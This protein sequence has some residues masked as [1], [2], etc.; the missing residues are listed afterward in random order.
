MATQWGVFNAEGCVEDGLW[1]L[2]EA[3]EAA[4]R[5]RSDGDDDA[6]ASPICDDH[7]EQPYRTCEECQSEEGEEGEEPDDDE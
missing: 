7:E 1:T 3:L 2:E 5:H 4:E 6:E